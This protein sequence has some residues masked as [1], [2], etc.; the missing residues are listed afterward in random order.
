MPEIIKRCVSLLAFKL[1]IGL[2]TK[3][4]AM[5]VTDSRTILLPWRDAKIQWGTFLDGG[6]IL[7]SGFADTGR[8]F[9]PEIW[10]SQPGA[11][12][13]PHSFVDG[14]RCRRT[15]NTYSFLVEFSQ[16]DA[17]TKITVFLLSTGEH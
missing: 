2:G 3:I 5:L 15:L 10:A 4:H 13:I 14:L 6:A 12:V 1:L 7:A 17:P 8:V 16:A 11:V 9:D